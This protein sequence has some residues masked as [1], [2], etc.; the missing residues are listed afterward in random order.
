MFL[1]KLFCSLCCCLRLCLW[2]M[3]EISFEDDFTIKRI[4]A[5]QH[6]AS[7]SV[8]CFNRTITTIVTQIVCGNISFVRWHVLFRTFN[9]QLN[10]LGD[11]SCFVSPSSPS[12][13]VDV[14][15]DSVDVVKV[16]LGRALNVFALNVLSVKLFTLWTKGKAA[17]V[18]HTHPHTQNKHTLQI[19]TRFLW[20]IQ[21]TK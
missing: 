5:L 10:E 20:C 19:T 18:E 17:A 21:T 3:V 8:D 15:A 13:S 12:A 11:M 2:L 1:N 16:V 4:T 9:F 7:T 14:R 6:K